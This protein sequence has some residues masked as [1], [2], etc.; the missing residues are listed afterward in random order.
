MTGR[1]GTA[2]DVSCPKCHAKVGADCT[3]VVRN[4]HGARIFAWRRKAPRK[5]QESLKALPMPTP[6]VAVEHAAQALPGTPRPITE[7]RLAELVR[8]VVAEVLM[9][10]FENAATTVRKKRDSLSRWGDC[11]SMC[12]GERHAIHQSKGQAVN[13]S[14]SELADTFDAM[15]EAVG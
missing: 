13:D 8:N 1:T 11:D 10:T 15:A 12:D 14:L 2:R 5:P 4:S 3:G 6:Q 9:R 7:E